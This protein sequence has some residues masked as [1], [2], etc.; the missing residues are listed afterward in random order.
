NELIAQE[1]QKYTKQFS[2]VEQ[3]RKF[4]LL[5]AEWSQASGELTPTLKVKRRVIEQKYAKEIESM[6][7][8]DMD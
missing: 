3:I 7:P 1:I 4:K 2:R 6:Y 8:K 5:E